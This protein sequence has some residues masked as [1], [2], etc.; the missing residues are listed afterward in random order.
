MAITIRLTHPP[1]CDGELH[2][3]VDDKQSHGWTNRTYTFTLAT[4][5][6]TPWADLVQVARDI[7]ANDA[8]RKPRPDRSG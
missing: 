4:K 6:D 8:R 3:T 5:T 1:E 2:I 7:L